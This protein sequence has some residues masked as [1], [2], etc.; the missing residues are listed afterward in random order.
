MPGDLNRELAH[1]GEMTDR[2]REM[3]TAAEAKDYKKAWKM[4]EDAMDVLQGWTTEL[5]AEIE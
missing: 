3:R 2:F 1:I 5:G 4:Y